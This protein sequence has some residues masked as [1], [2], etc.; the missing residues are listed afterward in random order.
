M[1]G[2]APTAGG[3][4]RRSARIDQAYGELERLANEFDAW[5]AH[6]RNADQLQ[7]YVSQLDALGSV[8]GGALE[9]VRSGLGEISA[10]QPIRNAYTDC[11]R[12]ERQVIWVR[13]L[14]GFF[15]DKWDQRDDPALAPVLAAADEIVWSCYALPFRRLGLDPGPAPLPYIEADF[16]PRTTV[17]DQLPQS[18]RPADRSLREAI[19]ELPLPVIGLPPL[20][21]ANPWWLVLAAH[22]VGHNVAAD[23]GGEGSMTELADLLGSVCGDGAGS[24]W[25]RWAE[26]VFADAYAAALVGSAHLWALVELEQGSD[27]MLLG[28]VPGYPP[29][30]VRHTLNA[31][32]LRALGLGE[33]VAIPG[34]DAPLQLA[35]LELSEE[36]RAKASYQLEPVPAIAEALASKELIAETDLAA[37][38]GWDPEKL[39][40]N[41]IAGW[42]QG[43]FAEQR[44]IG[45][46]VALE[47]ARLAAVGALGEWTRIATD[48][49]RG[50]REA[51]SELLRE[52][53]LAVIVR[54]RPAEVRAPEPEAFD[55]EQ[56]NTAVAVAVSGISAHEE[57]EPPLGE[58]AKAKTEAG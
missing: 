28:R 12:A 15:R 54:C 39:S 23:L 27:Q 13:K 19:A 41:G 10:E 47:A 3:A 56:L 7:Q 46:E 34:L 8:V 5:I 30:L 38:S 45:A 29:P 53:M 20:C 52:E 6:R 33:E 57:E 31:C 16:S 1:A 18:L 49:D 43:K 37:L 14:W 55:L 11:L 51:R 42:W 36:E 4:A 48:P 35:A 40:S 26:E 50:R 25:C 22:E 17:R 58:I 44:E 9:T 21:V 32:L 2:G 24:E